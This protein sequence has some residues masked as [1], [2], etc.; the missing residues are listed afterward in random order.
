MPWQFILIQCYDVYLDNLGI[1]SLK[2]GLDKCYLKGVCY[3]ALY[4]A[5]RFSKFLHST[6]A[7]W[8]L[9]VKFKCVYIS[10]VL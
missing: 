4:L 5:F 2:F 7:I 3:S 10:S 8:F 9:K 1:L 6:S